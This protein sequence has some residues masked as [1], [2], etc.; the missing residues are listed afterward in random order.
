MLGLLTVGLVLLWEWL[1]TRLDE[2]YP[3]GDRA[4]RFAVRPA[5]P[6]L[7]TSGTDGVAVLRDVGAPG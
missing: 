1:P 4:R 5:Y 3:F 6:A 2:D 7:L